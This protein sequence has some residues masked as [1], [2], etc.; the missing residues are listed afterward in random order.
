[1][2]VLI[3]EIIYSL[4]ANKCTTTRSQST[5]KILKSVI[6]LKIKKHDIAY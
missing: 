5:L 6:S 3:I 2:V 4:N 1:M